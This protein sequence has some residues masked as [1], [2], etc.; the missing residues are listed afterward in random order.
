MNHKYKGYSAK[1]IVTDGACPKCGMNEVQVTG[2]FTLNSSI[3]QDMLC[4]FC[5]SEYT[6]VYELT[7]VV[8]HE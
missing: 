5:G 4:R 8:V 3:V 7:K 1:E 6:G 2:T